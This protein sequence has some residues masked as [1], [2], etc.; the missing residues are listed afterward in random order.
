MYKNPTRTTAP[1]VMGSVKLELEQEEAKEREA[2][3]QK[4]SYADA[5]QDASRVLPNRRWKKKK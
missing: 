3:K 2:E 1:E 5:E 4:A